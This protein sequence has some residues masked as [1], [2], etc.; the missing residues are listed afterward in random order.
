L[1]G[2]NGKVEEVRKL[3]QNEQINMN[4]QDSELS[5]TFFTLLVKKDL[6]K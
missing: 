5:R 6:L 3:I 1:A 2:S 4:W